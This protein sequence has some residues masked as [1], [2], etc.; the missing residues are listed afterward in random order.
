VS[1]VGAADALDVALGIRPAPNYQAERTRQLAEMRAAL[2]EAAFQAAWAA[3]QA[4]SLE[5]AVELALAA[6]P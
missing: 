1:L 2:G 5:A 3:G 4:L 6:T